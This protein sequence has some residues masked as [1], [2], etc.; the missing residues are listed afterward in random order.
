MKK[1]RAEHGQLQARIIAIVRDR[2]QCTVRDVH[3]EIRQERDV[4]YTTVL[5]VMTRLAERGILDRSRTG[6]VGVFSIAVS[7]DPDAA[8]QVI[9]HLI[10]RF[11]SVAVA[12]FVAN[13]KLDPDLM[14]QLRNLIEKED[15]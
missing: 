13:A 5:T 10:G 15:A 12:Q 7:S 14:Q 1:K 4:A 2:C 8:N 3:E 11:G 9:E 6:N